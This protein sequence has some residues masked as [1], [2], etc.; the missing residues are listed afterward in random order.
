MGRDDEV[1]RVGALTGKTDR[2]QLRGD[3][4]AL[5][6]LDDPLRDLAHEEIAVVMREHP[7]A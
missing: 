7:R 5:Q 2:L 3:A 6:P 1:D 4:E